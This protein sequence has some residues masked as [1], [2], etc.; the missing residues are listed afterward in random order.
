MPWRI[1][2]FEWQLSTTMYEPW[3]AVSERMKEAVGNFTDC[4]PCSRVPAARPRMTPCLRDTTVNQVGGLSKLQTTH[5][6]GG[7]VKLIAT[8][9]AATLQ[10]G[11]SLGAQ[12]AVI[13]SFESGL[14]GWSYIGDVSVQSSSI[15]LDPTHGHQMAFMS[16]MCDRD[17]L[18]SQGGGCET[19]VNEHPYS[20]VSSPAAH[21]AREFLG[22]PSFQHDFLAAMPSTAYA[23][24]FG[25][26][27]AMKYRFYAPHSGALSFDWN[28]IGADGDSAYLSL[29]SDDGS[30]RTS[31]WIFNYPSFTGSFANSGV[32]LCA[33]YYT[34]S[35]IRC[36]IPSSLNV[37]TGWQTKT[38]EILQ[39]G[40]YTIGFGLGE[41]A[42]GTV[43]TVLALDNV[44]FNALPE[45]GTG[46]LTLSGVG[47]LA[48][49]A[50]RRKTP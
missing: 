39:T 15:G 30:F 34:D 48:L 14:G 13:S 11:V 44:R 9:I 4:R 22:L 40:W 36:N 10:L 42:E 31:D 18:P 38:V 6:S 50:R 12:A 7:G 25:E 29:W 20:G 35:E 46:I 47:L 17:N 49:F 16:T 5:C 3:R 33:R 24:I 32:D 8:A 43:P 28:R 41:I 19:T 21:F 37:E 1:L 26:G 45:P 2:R 27:S 23:A